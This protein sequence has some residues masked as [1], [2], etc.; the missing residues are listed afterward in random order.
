MQGL[1]SWMALQGAGAEATDYA[2]ND[3]AHPSVDL[4]ARPWS[5]QSARRRLDRWGPMTARGR[6][7]Y[8]N[9]AR[10]CFNVLTLR[11]R[12]FVSDATA[13]SAGRSGPRSPRLRIGSPCSGETNAGKRPTHR[14]NDVRGGTG[15]RHLQ[16]WTSRHLIG[17]LWVE[18]RSRA[19][20]IAAITAIRS[21]EI[22]N[23]VA[24]RAPTAALAKPRNSVPVAERMG[25]SAYGFVTR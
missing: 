6:L 23:N 2:S 20:R 1:V 8:D 9:R 10:E 3:T 22:L 19:V 17:L 13:D 14:R 18:G 5:N 15:I 24:K 25:T 4:G 12:L 7:T 21:L 11:V 16:K